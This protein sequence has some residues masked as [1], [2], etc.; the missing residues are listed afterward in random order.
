MAVVDVGTVERDDDT[1][2]VQQGAALELK[3]PVFA[4]KKTA[5]DSAIASDLMNIE[6]KNLTTVFKQNAV[7]K[8]SPV[9]SK[10]IKLA[11]RRNQLGLA[12]SWTPTIDIT[13]TGM[14]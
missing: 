6:K 5:K 12:I 9:Q 13:L 14:R 10:Q 3:Q 8:L 4:S 1:Q 7:N 11:L 2:L